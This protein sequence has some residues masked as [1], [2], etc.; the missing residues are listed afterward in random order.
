[1][2]LS[3]IQRFMQR[4][5]WGIDEASLRPVQRMGISLL[6]RIIITVE[7]FLG[8][9]LSSFT[10]ALTYSCMLAAV[11]VLAI[12]FAIARGFGFGSLIEDRLRANIQLSDD[13]TNTVFSFIEHY[14]ERAKGG[15]FVGVGLL[16]LIYTVVM[17]TSNI[18]TAFNTIW[19]VKS[20]RNI[21]RR[22]TNYVSV[23]LFT[24]ILIV[25]TSGFS[26]FMV[27]FTS[28]FSKY[29]LL[30]STMGF[31]IKITPVLLSGLAFTALYKFM[32]N[33]R[34]HWRATLVP[35]LLAGS[36]FQVLQY[37]YIH[38]QFLLS[39]YN[40]I[41]G[42][43]AALPLFMLWMQFSWYICL[44]GAQMSYANQ[45]VSEYA[46][47]KDSQHLSRRDHDSVALLIMSRI[48][49]RYAEGIAP[50][51][52]HSLAIETRLPHALVQGLL[53]EMV[54]SGI[55]YETS[56]ETGT[57]KHFLPSKDIHSISV[58]W[59]LHQLDI[60]GEGQ[61]HHSWA[62]SN[63]EW[64]AIRDLRTNI[65]AADGSTLVMNL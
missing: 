24:P 40:A 22:I 42:S 53:D 48:C 61:L 12:V 31:M 15:V 7:S 8:N 23:F 25:V 17:L 58:D 21:Y 4:D 39:S 27:T 26:V 52:T 5:I 43:F 37:V 13:I 29:I 59:V 45:C 28:V 50:Y 38:Y 49:K 35:G 18:E 14:L 51:S 64:E 9:N 55:V 54:V 56:D 3:T 33:T 63:Q 34:V 19:Q 47:A 46:Y 6:K 16:L 44:I 65:S 10:A 62:I 1:M 11:P 32:P 36:L 57:L 60:Y 41:Y 30:S 20:S 2:K